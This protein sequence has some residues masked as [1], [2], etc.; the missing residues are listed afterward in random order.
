[1]YSVRERQPAHYFHGGQTAGSGGGDVFTDDLIARI[2]VNA[3][4][5]LVDYNF[6]ELP[7]S[8]LEGTVFADPNGDCQF[9]SGDTPLSGVTVQLLDEFGEVVAVQ[10]TNS[11]GKYRFENLAPGEYSVREL[12]PTSYFHGGQTAGSGG[13]SVETADLIAG[14][15]IAGGEHLVNY[16]FCESPAARISGNVFQDGPPISGSEQ[17]LGPLEVGLLRDGK[18]TADDTPLAGVLLQLRDGFTGDPIDASEAL[19][20]LYP[21]GPIQV[22]TDANGRYEFKGVPGG[23]SY[24]VYEIHP[25]AYID[26]IDTVGSTTGFA[27]NPQSVQGQIV[28][29]PLAGQ[30]ASDAI[31][32][33]G[34]APGQSSENN[35]F[36]EV[37]AEPQ[38]VPPPDPPDPPVIFPPPPSPPPPL[39]ET[40]LPSQTRM[41]PMQSV[42]SWVAPRQNV[43]AETFAGAIGY[44]WHL[45]VVNGG[46]PRD[47]ASVSE[48]DDE[49]W[50]SA[51]YLDQTNWS[52]DKM[53]DISWV[54]GIN[55]QT[56][57]RR[58]HRSLVFGM[59]G[60]I[61]FTGDF[62][63]DGTSEIGVFYRGEWFVDLNG[64]GVWDES[65]M[66]AKL[67]DELDRP[68][69]GDW[70]GDGKDDIGIYG[71]EWFGDQRQIGKESGLPDSQNLASINRE[72]KPKNVPP[73]EEE[74]TDGRR[75]LRLN[76]QGPRR[77]DVIDHVFRYGGETD[78]PVAGDWNGD[79]IRTVGIFRGGEWQ[80]DTNGDGLADVRDGS[81]RF[82]RAGDIPVVG[83]W[84]GNGVEEIGVFRSGR[85][86]LDTNG[87]RELDAHDRVFEMGGAGDRPVVGD[88]NGDGIDEPGIYRELPPQGDVPVSN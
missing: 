36:S 22:R 77:S 75:L 87:N 62:N 53:H 18:L 59:R 33:I 71:P 57:S 67:G 6:C 4:E 69:V 45:S 25:T 16:N 46:M 78:S 54:L 76:A 61:P 43:M 31:I 72:Q 5:D 27:F 44:S 50:R 1:M 55:P 66:W 14:I 64:N 86:V 34:V 13:G 56:D 41:L 65:D 17:D 51:T 40:W 38:S 35:N 83:D 84:D 20:G 47:I 21:R 23:R 58:N 74:A 88:W 82:G 49:V 2:F 24:A 11:A 15:A 85:W 19:P 60:S 8:T 48:T 70:D 68:V 52:A 63:G 39:L 32:R 37:K 26:G 81:F 7:P 3:G 28:I 10:T 42:I 79:G 12:Q 73:P 29:E 30:P 9:N 80:I